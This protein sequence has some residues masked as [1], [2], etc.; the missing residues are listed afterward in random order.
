MGEDSK[1]GRC[2]RRHN[3]QTNNNNNNK[4]LRILWDFEIQTDYLISARRPDL[5]I[6]D[7]K[8]KEKKKE[9]KGTLRIVVFAVPVDHRKKN[10]KKAKRKKEVWPCRRSKQKKSCWT[11]WSWWWWY[12]LYLMCWERSP[13]GLIRELEELEIGGRAETLKTT[14]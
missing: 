3:K 12:Q 9:K 10:P 13:N 7:R 14:A 8:K 5:M 1:K 4:T 11:W 6:V 2:P